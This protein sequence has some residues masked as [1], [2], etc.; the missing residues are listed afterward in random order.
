MGTNCARP[1]RR[2]V[3][4]GDERE[5]ATGLTVYTRN[6]FNDGNAE[7]SKEWTILP[8]DSTSGTFSEDGEPSS[9]IV[10]VDSRE[11]IGGFLTSDTGVRQSKDIT[12]ATLTDFLLDRMRGN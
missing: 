12:Y 3:S 8:F 1:E 5:N 2:A 7:T 6:Y 11:R 10:H 4:Y 9:V